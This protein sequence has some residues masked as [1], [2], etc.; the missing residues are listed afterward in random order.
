MLAVK[1]S[2]KG[3]LVLENLYS[4]FANI[5]SYFISITKII[6]YN[7]NIGGFKLLAERHTYLTPFYRYTASFSS[8]FSRKYFL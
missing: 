5:L 8:I 2:T 4:N 7:Y 1:F 6:G 3:I